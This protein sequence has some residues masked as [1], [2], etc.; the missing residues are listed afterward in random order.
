MSDCGKSMKAGD[1][2]IVFEA[3]FGEINSDMR[4]TIVPG[5]IVVYVEWLLTTKH[6]TN[7]NFYFQSVLHDS[8][9]HNSF[10]YDNKP[11][12]WHLESIIGCWSEANSLSLVSL[13]RRF[14]H[15]FDSVPRI[16]HLHTFCLRSGPELK[17]I[18]FV[19]IVVA[20]RWPCGA[21][22][23]AHA[24]IYHGNYHGVFHY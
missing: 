2:P 12:L 3:V 13:L 14:D 17:R 23:W 1:I 6:L 7:L 18:Y 9:L 10:K 15:R 16:H 24:F 4:K 5:F 21:N 20:E 22:F 11:S 19:A 8:I